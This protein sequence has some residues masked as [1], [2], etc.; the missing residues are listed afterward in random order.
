MKKKMSIYDAIKLGTFASVQ[1]ALDS[2]AEINPPDGTMSPLMQAINVG[3]YY[4]IEYF[5]EKGANVNCSDMNNTALTLAVANPNIT[6]IKLLLKN[7]AN[8][9]L[10][11]PRGMTPLTI[12]VENYIAY[13]D[14]QR[15]MAD[16]PDPPYP[17]EELA[18]TVINLL[19]KHKADP[20]LQN[21]QGESP[22]YLAVHWGKDELVR[23]LECSNRKYRPI[24]TWLSENYRWFWGLL[25]GSITY[26]IGKYIG[27]Q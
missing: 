10:I 3:N 19:L 14:E 24:I 7:K 26:L 22:T 25:I 13:P 8:P 6:I 21:S 11:D 15:E 9:N 5:I 4:L 1:E 20:T 16:Y 27:R 17:N 2:G 12:A 18:L 23:I